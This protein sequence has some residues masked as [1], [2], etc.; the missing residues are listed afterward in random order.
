M[1]PD[2][3]NGPLIRTAPPKRETSL[4]TILIMTGLFIPC[5]EAIGDDLPT[6]RV[7]E[8]RFLIRGML[9]ATQKVRSGQVDISG[10]ILATDA[11]GE[12]LEGPVS[13][14]YVFDSAIRHY[15]YEMTAP[16]N[17]AIKRPDDSAV[18]SI[19]SFPSEFK[20][21]RTGEYYT[22][23]SRSTPSTHTNITLQPVEADTR[24]KQKAC[25]RRPID[26][27]ASGVMGYFEFSRGEEA[28][29]V[30]EGLLSIAVESFEAGEE[31]ITIGLKDENSE[32]TLIVDRELQA[33]I[34]LTQRSISDPS[35][36]TCH[37]VW[38]R[39]GDVVVPVALKAH[40]VYPEI[41]D[42]LY[43]YEL[44]WSRVNDV[45]DPDEFEYTAFT[46]IQG[47]GIT[48]VFDARGA[49]VVHVGA[50]ESDGNVVMAHIPQTGASLE[51]SGSRNT[52]RLVIV[53]NVIVLLVLLVAYVMRR[54]R[55]G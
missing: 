53:A 12:R 3:R 25:N 1:K 40:F 37:A 21:C 49:E 27:M 19:N 4:A 32:Y 24:D 46:G 23:W 9:D 8:A 11:D 10:N 48:E 26:V 36:F 30:Y 55:V 31:Q 7:H 29:D 39:K 20:C 38:I 42:E 14:R 16:C 52:F 51:T 28:V 41:A 13:G 50:W 22:E 33:P 54:R 6:E 45:F 2:S 34:S 18:E 35:H 15:R 47:G 44:T 43:E 17:V 5:D